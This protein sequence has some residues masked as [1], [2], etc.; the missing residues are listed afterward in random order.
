MTRPYR[1]L[2]RMVLFLLAVIA[3]CVALRGGLTDAFLANPPLNGMIIGVLLLG[4]GYNFRQVLVLNPEV[5]WIEHFRRDQ[6]KLSRYKP[7]RLLAP[8]ATMLG[9]R[10]GRVS[11]SAIATRSMLDSIGSRL[12]ESRDI[13]RYLIGLEIFLGLL[14]TFWGLLETVG[15]VS[16]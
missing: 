13:S 5:T 11:L 8:M 3:V 14:G 7:P 2:F 1:F 16:S 4:I 10:K 15:A 12:D 9:E 6:P